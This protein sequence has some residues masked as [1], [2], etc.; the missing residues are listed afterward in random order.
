MNYLR[1]ETGWRAVGKLPAGRVE[2]LVRQGFEIV[3]EL[4]KDQPVEAGW[5]GLGDAF[6]SIA[7][8]I[9]RLLGMDCVDKTIGELKPES[10]CA[11]RRAKLN[12]AVPF[13]SH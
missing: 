3:D 12:K 13:G 4:P 2:F 7:T 5:R 11:K 10:E 8:P 1:T 6:A 9:A